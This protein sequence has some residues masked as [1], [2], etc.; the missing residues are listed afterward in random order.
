MLALN[1]YMSRD[2]HLHIPHAD[3]WINLGRKNFTLSIPFFCFEYCCS[4]SQ[5]SAWNSMSTA[6]LL[7]PIGLATSIISALSQKMIPKNGS[8]SCNVPRERTA[9]HLLFL[10]LKVPGLCPFHSPSHTASPPPMLICIT[11][12]A[13]AA[14]G[15]KDSRLETPLS[16]S[17][18]QWKISFTS[19]KTMRI[20]K[21]EA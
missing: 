8:R 1:Q 7:E 16:N 2:H 13:G 15:A 6:F 20:I 14:N 3:F 21:R 19:R 10:C 5:Y 9:P 18:E 17:G 12:A 11:T 4:S